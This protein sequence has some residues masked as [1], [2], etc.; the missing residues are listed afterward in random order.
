[1]RWRKRILCDDGRRWD[2]EWRGFDKKESR[3]EHVCVMDRWMGK[4][5]RGR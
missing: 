1:M 4:V 2:E 5:S 3:P